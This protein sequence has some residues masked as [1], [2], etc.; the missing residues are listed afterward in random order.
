MMKARILASE[1]PPAMLDPSDY[2]TFL[3]DYIQKSSGKSYGFR[4]TGGRGLGQQNKS[5]LSTAIAVHEDFNTIHELV[6]KNG[7]TYTT[8]EEYIMYKQQIDRSVLE[9]PLCLAL[10]QDVNPQIILYLLGVL[11]YNN[12]IYKD[13]KGFINW[14][15][16]PDHC[17]LDK[18]EL[19]EGLM[20]LKFDEIVSVIQSEEPQ[21]T[22]QM[23]GGR[24]TRHRK[25]R[26][27]KHRA[28]KQS[29]RKQTRRRQ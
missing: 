29:A 11:I 17:A 27:R 20:L 28:R 13:R 16:Q 4:N 14:R 18:D 12:K 2:K 5:N 7:N 15:Q 1:A 24:R 25:H 6:L 26:A 19:L 3:R 21:W 23:S 9:S 10:G 22:P 8:L